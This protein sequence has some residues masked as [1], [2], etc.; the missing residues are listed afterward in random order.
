MN[1]AFW[2]VIGTLGDRP[3]RPGCQSIPKCIS[4]VPGRART[5]PYASVPRAVSR[6]AGAPSHSHRMRPAMCAQRS[7]GRVYGGLGRP[8]AK[9]ARA[10][11]RAYAAN[12][13]S[14]LPIGRARHLCAPIR[15]ALA[16][17]CLPVCCA[18]TG[19]ARA[20][21]CAMRPPMRVRAVAHPCASCMRAVVLAPAC[22]SP[23]AIARG[24]ETHP[25][26]GAPNRM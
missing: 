20:G 26:K 17:A 8:S 15:D 6:F 24:C 13:I 4:R 14:R 19:R 23:Y 22:A 5:G 1:G 11:S 12:E 16:R 3:V 18:A 9:H 2:P 10:P 7:A 21:V 25:R